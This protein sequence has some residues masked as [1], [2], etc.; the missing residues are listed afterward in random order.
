MCAPA[1][2]VKCP[3][4]PDGPGSRPR[5]ARPSYGGS[6]ADS[7]Q[8]LVRFVT[9]ERRSAGPAPCGRPRRRGEVM[10]G[11]GGAPAQKAPTPLG[12]PRPVGPSQPVL[13]WHHCVVGQEP[14]LPEVTSKSEACV[15]VRQRVGI[16]RGVAA[17]RVHR[18]DDRRREAGAAVLRPACCWSAWSGRR[19]PAR[20][21]GRPRPRRRPSRAWCIPC[22]PRRPRRVPRLPSSSRSPHRS[23]PSRSSRGCWRQQRERC[24]RP[25]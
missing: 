8:F 20:S 11:S 16:P 7:N 10:S 17:Q 12:V 19:P 23:R 4:M 3:G 24:H 25:L 21:A 6:V 2:E 13:A 18:G 15:L 9:I 22:R 14:L 5:P 1:T